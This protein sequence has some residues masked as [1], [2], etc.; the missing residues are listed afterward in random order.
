MYKYLKICQVTIGNMLSQT[1]HSLQKPGP[2][3]VT[4]PFRVTVRDV[5]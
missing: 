3:A 4:L 5:L 2:Q 1:E